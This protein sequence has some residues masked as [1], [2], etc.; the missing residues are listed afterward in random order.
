MNVI[1]GAVLQQ[2]RVWMRRITG[3]LIEVNDSI[4]DASI[5][6]P[7]VIG[8][9]YLLPFLSRTRKAHVGS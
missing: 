7:L 3:Y 6:D 9:S 2:K 8:L 5:P 4:K 1:A